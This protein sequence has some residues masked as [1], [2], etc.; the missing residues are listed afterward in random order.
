MQQTLAAWSHAQ[1]CWHNGVWKGIGT[2]WCWKGHRMALWLLCHWPQEE[3]AVSFCCKPVSMWLEETKNCR[4]CLCCGGQWDGLALVWLDP[5]GL[6]G[7]RQWGGPGWLQNLCK[8]RMRACSEEMLNLLPPKAHLDRV[9]MSM[10]MG[11]AFCTPSGYDWSCFVL[12]MWQWQHCCSIVG[13]GS[14]MLLCPRDFT[15]HPVFFQARAEIPWYWLLKA[16][17]PEIVP[18]P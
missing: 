6:S 14:Q 16:F 5:Q 8:R 4:R 13:S 10:V 1:F 2:K 12:V 7:C 17:R 9:N 18:L 3:Q 15:V 11:S